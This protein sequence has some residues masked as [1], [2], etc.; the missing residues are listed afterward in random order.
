MP[1]DVYMVKTPGGILIPSTDECREAMQKLPNGVEHKVSITRPRNIKFHRKMFALFRCGYEIWC[2]TVDT[3]KEYKGCK[4]MTDFHQFRADV[5]ILAGY[6]QATF[7]TDG[8]VRFNAKSLSFHSMDDEEFERA[9]NDVL[10]VILRKVI[11]SHGITPEQMRAYVDN[12][13]SFA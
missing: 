6:Y 8:S 1:T 11:P 5:L 3:N 9:F 4:V 2:E 13:I 12:V 7:R 10:N